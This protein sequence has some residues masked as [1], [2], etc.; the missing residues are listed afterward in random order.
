MEFLPKDLTLALQAAQNLAARKKSR[1]RVK[2]GTS[3]FP[4]LR[5][6]HDGLAMDAT[7]TPHLRGTV[8]VYDGATHIFHCLII[9][10][11]VEGQELVCEFKHATRVRDRAAL[12]YYR[13]EN[14]PVG[15]LPQA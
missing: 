10:S 13:D 7:V 2:V 14:A 1:L 6:W 15:Y 3:I 4:V 12:D 9:A 5:M 8:D 11:T